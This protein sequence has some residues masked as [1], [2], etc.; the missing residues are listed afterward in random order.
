[1]DLTQY[2]RLNS[3]IKI[4][5]SHLFCKM[6]FSVLVKLRQSDRKYL[7]QPVEKEK[8]VQCIESARLSPSA[9]NSQPWRFIIVDD[10]NLV[11]EMAG[12]VNML[13]LNKFADQVPVFIA[14]VVEKESLLSTIHGAMSN[15]AYYLMDIGMAVNQLC[16]QA[17][18]LG[19]GTCI[20]GWFDEKKVKKLLKVNKTKRV[21][22]LISIGYPASKTRVK[23]RKSFNEICSWNRYR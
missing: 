17:T 23:S 8:L 12:Y 18:D 7:N 1:M 10:Q 16:L 2:F 4:K 9:N 3:L 13:G 11:K 6:E 5:T 14:V 21:P 22:L 15:K 20:I 19:L